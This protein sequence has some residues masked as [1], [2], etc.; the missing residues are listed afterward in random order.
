MQT[1][2]EKITKVLDTN[3]AEAIEVFDLRD[4][5]YFVDYAIIASSLG[6]RHT[7]ALLDHLKKD[8]KATEKFNQVDESGD[9]IVVDLGDVLIHIMTPEYRVKYD[10]ESFLTKLS[11][12]KEG[13]EL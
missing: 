5:N 2:I 4:K 13:D 8:L 7:L 12:G 9:W 1:R 10:M 6:T 11:N 3:K